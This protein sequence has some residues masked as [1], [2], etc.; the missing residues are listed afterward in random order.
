MSGA[1]ASGS[2]SAGQIG[3]ADAHATMGMG[4]HVGESGTGA[5]VGIEET[6]DFD[7]FARRCGPDLRRVL[8]ARYGADVGIEAAA[9]ALAYAWERWARVAT[10]ENPTGYLVRVGQSAARRY[11][12]RP[13]VMPARR[14]PAESSFDPRLPRALERLSPRQRSAVVL[15]CVH[16]WTYPA[17]AAALGVSESTLRNHVR[18]GLE[19]LRRELGEG[20]E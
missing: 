9:D 17:A 14:P 8:V 4:V 15:I 10:M 6:R 18:R 7:T 3:K 5:Q 16:D 19:R 20:S 12:R 1:D 2:T 13:V 11:R